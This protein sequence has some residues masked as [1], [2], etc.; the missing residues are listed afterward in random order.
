MSFLL[1]EFVKKTNV[2]RKHKQNKTKTI[3]NERL[4]KIDWTPK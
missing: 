3:L 4:G 1:I 2:K